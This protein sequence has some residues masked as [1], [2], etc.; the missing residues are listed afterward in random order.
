MN[1][2]AQAV[3]R[4]QEYIERHLDEQITLI[5]LARIA[6]YSPYHAAHL[7]SALLGVS[8][9]RYIRQLRLSGAA[10]KIR[11]END[12]ILQIAFD[13]Q[14][15]SH[16]GFAK[17]FARQFGMSPREYRRNSPAIPLFR[18]YRVITQKQEVKFMEM[19]AV[20]VQL[21]HRP[22]RKAIILR[23][24]QAE[25]YFAY[26]EEVGCDVW[27][28]LCSV[29]EA[30]NEPMG[31]WLPDRLI[32]PGTSRYVQ[33]VEVPSDYAKPLPDGFETI[34]LEPCTYMVFQSE[35]YDD[36]VFE[37]MILAIQ[38][39]IDRYHP[40][41]VGYRFDESIAPL[42]QLEPRGERGYIEA[43]PVVKI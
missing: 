33:G 19:Q 6:G 3:I 4:M 16:E 36:E 21:I 34:L 18:P 28:V 40:E 5:Q 22:L 15:D 14:F 42:Y 1:E 39:S 8:P 17:A 26:C 35:P 12:A 23:A 13:Y 31:M 11:D 2:N 10:K 38:A 37:Q 29:K 43:R 32:Q 41:N 20:F 24:K 7:F 30:L 9:L 25:E 27:G